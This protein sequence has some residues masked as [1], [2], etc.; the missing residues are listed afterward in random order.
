MA[1]LNCKSCEDLRKEVPELIA[2]GFTDTMC[3]SLKNDTG[4]KTSS[5][6][7]DCTDLNNLNDCLIGNAETE[8][9]R[10]DTCDWKDFTKNHINN[11]WTTL[12][13]IICAI[14][15]LWTNVH[16]LWATLRSLCITKVGNKIRLTSNLGTHC[17]VTDSDTT[18][19]LTISG[20]KITLT[21]SD[22]TTDTVTVP[23]NNTTYDLTISGHTVKLSGS[24]GSEDLVTVP[25][26][27]TTYTLTKSGDTITL[28]DSSGHTWS[29][30]D[31]DTKF[32]PTLNT[33]TTDGYV[34]K[35]QNQPNKVWKTDANGNPAWRDDDSGDF[36]K[37]K[38]LIDKL[39]EG[40]PETNFGFGE[41]STGSSKL[42]PGTGVDFK[43][44][45]SSQAHTSDVTLRYIAGGNSR[46][47]GSL[48]LFTESFKDVS[49]NTKS[50]NSVW[51]FTSNNW[52]GIPQ[53]GERL[54]DILIKKSEYPQLDKLYD[55]D[56]FYTGSSNRFVQAHVNVFDG[57][58]PPDGQ[59]DT[60]AYGQHGWCNDNGTPSE[61]GYS[62][63]IKV[64]KGYI[65]ISVRLSHITN[66]YV[67][68]VK[69]GAGNT[70]QGCNMTLAGYVG[71]RVNVE[72]LEET[73]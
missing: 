33:K 38:C 7:N 1:D 58:N 34:E 19:D 10:Y 17:E 42:I 4:L 44:R 9:E 52:V 31:D 3:A 5:G 8:I 18:Y 62:D 70:K 73:C 14:C 49:G 45:S 26:N 59:A 69:D 37:L 29:V 13:A 66:G 68:D 20:H 55:A 12:K 35:G 36:D 2:N 61:S 57:D 53:G 21:G 11:L 15:G 56:L 48:R 50:G 63:G 54:Y 32:T 60:Y 27:N 41:D 46:L 6:H 65:R 67:G 43:I 64:N 72:K 71:M 28:T 24:D 30:K 40:S 47:S 23:D 51:N 22:G 25:D 39:F 16:N